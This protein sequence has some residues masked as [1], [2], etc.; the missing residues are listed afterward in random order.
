M[1]QLT[2]VSKSISVCL[3]YEWILFVECPVKT[4]LKTMTFLILPFPVQNGQNPM[5][6]SNK[7]SYSRRRWHYHWTMQIGAEINSAELAEQKATSHSDNANLSAAWSSCR[8]PHSNWVL[9]QSWQYTFP[10][11]LPEQDQTTFLLADP[12]RGDLHLCKLRYT[13]SNLYPQ[14]SLYNPTCR[15]KSSSGNWYPGDWKSTNHRITTVGKDLQDP[16]AKP[17]PTM[18]TV[19]QCHIPTVLEHLHGR[20]PHHSLG[21]CATAA[22]L[23][24]RCFS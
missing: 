16:Q 18:P 4:L 1:L 20:R 23:F 3:P 2:M 21:S 7:A 8:T 11:W 24:L 9:Q 19:P 17:T 13:G 12:G 14:C 22:L 6:L 10:F 5:L 15:G